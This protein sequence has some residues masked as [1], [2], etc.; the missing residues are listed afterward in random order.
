MIETP[1]ELVAARQAHQTDRRDRAT[2]LGGGD[3]ADLLQIAPYGCLRKLVLGK[4]ERIEQDLSGN[5]NV[6]RGKRLE[7]VAADVYTE[8]TGRKLRSHSARMFDNERLGMN[9]DRHIV[10]FDQRG[11]GV[12]EIKCPSQFV[13]RRYKKEGLPADYSAQLNWYMGLKDWDWGAFAI[14]SAELDELLA[15]DVTFDADLYF[16]QVM[17]AAKAW[18]LVD[19]GPLPEP[20]DPKSKACGRCQY[21]ERCHPSEIPVADAGELIQILTPELAGALAD[22]KAAK[23]VLDEAEALKADAEDRIKA[24]VGAATAI[25]AP[26]ARIYFRTQSRSSVDAAKLTKLYPDAA[27]ACAKLSTFRTLRI[28]ERTN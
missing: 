7:A 24:I 22:R 4:R 28:Y 21:F 17:E 5:H 12:L 8:I 18:K 26:G 15:F 25:E 9:M 13:F 11:P 27:S 1:Q 10:E 14:Y 6:R 23:E 20:L 2:Y 3:M 16:T 19:F